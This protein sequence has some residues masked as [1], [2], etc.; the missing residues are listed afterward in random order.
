MIIKFNN[1]IHINN[2]KSYSNK[3]EIRTSA[4]YFFAHFFENFK[5]T[6]HRK[7]GDPPEIVDLKVEKLHFVGIQ[8]DGHVIID[9]EGK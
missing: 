9:L 6:I 2:F 7:S 5:M 1:R 4:A 3:Q 8:K